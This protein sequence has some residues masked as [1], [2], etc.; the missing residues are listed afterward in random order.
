M[1]TVATDPIDTRPGGVRATTDELLRL[2]GI[3]VSFARRGDWVEVV[4]GVDL[5]VR[6]HETVGLVGES[7]SG[8]SVTCMTA[9]GLIRDLGGRL[10]SG[11]VFL[12][13]EDVTNAPEKRLRQLRS[14]FVS[15]IFQQPTRSLNPAYTVGDQVAEVLRI[16]RG[17]GRKEAWA[18][19]VSLLDRVH[20]DRAA[21]RAHDYPH[22][23]SGGMCQRVMI[24]I[25]IACRPRLLIADEPTTALDTTVQR[26]V[27]NLL[28]ELKKELGLGVLYVSHDLGV[29]R[30]I[31]ERTVVMY[32]G[33]V[34]EESPTDD[35]FR[36]P[37]HPYTHGLISS[38]PGLN[39]KDRLGYIPGSVPDMAELP[40]GCRFHPRCPWSVE[41]CTTAPV[42]LLP[43]G[44]RRAARCIRTEELDLRGEP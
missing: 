10:T 20:I 29:V 11:R 25:A 18:E 13:G 32:A 42:E 26:Q 21:E 6:A 2:D 28:D 1:P 37:K 35:A 7:G 19:A 8:K 31:A 16:K 27:L 15:A 43:V 44:E 12:D 34:V 17:M 3:S 30:E 41:A 36:R 4:S 23:L 9:A 38:T 33:Q 14:S 40:S 22:M 24:A 39:P 5:I